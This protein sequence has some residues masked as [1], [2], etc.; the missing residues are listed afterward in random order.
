MNAVEYCLLQGLAAAGPD[1]PAIACAEETVSYGALA[2]RVAQF[3]AGLREIGVQ[4]N[5]RVAMQMLDTPDLVAL[6]QAAMAAGAVAVAVSSRTSADELK[7]ILAVVQPAVMVV[8]AEFAADAERALV[9][10]APAAKLLRRDRELAIWKEATAGQL[11]PVARAPTDPAFWVMTSGTTGAPK[12]VEHCHGNVGICAQYYEQVLGASKADRLFATSRFH[13]AYAIGN[14]FASLRL[15]ST[16]I[17]L[18]RW[19]TADSV[20]ATAERF[21]PTILL[22]VPA[23]YHRLIE[24]DLPRMPAFRSLR[25]LVSA[26]ERLPPQLCNAWQA[27]TGQPIL[28]GLGASEL[29]Y[30]V[31]GNRPGCY[32]PGSSGHAMPSVELRIVDETGRVVAEADKPGRLEV[33]MP[34]VCIGYR[35]ANADLGGPP[36]RPIDSFRPDGWFATGDEYVRDAEGFY[37]H[38]GRTGDMLRVTGMWIS[39]SEIE[40][41]LAGIPSIAES[42]AVLGESRV[43]LGEVVLFIVPATPAVASA[44]LIDARDR[45]GKVLPP[46]KRPRRFEIVADLPRTATGK[47]QRHKLRKLAQQTAL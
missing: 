9:G 36:E 43:G 41:A 3:A 19:A 28:D 29:V 18:E 13:F 44:A 31:I 5:D 20:A 34:S 22:S 42:A 40:D 11:A 26:G 38:R 12:A 17:L 2:A 14:N 27:A 46:H 1:H 15:G 23:V 24:A 10:L 21:N 25:H 47:V 39:P 6:H 30:M 32:R 37:H 4:P 33:R 35:S 7:Q 16:N 45:L 8:D